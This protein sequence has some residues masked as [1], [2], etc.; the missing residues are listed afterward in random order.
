MAHYIPFDS[1]DELATRLALVFVVCISSDMIHEKDY[2][3]GLTALH[4]ISFDVCL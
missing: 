4:N 1:V 2:W 3:Y